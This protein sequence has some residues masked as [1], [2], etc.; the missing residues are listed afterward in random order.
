MFQTWEP[1]GDPFPAK[2]LPLREH[3]AHDMFNHSTVMSNSVISASVNRGDTHTHGKPV[4]LWHAS[5]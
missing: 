1:V 3:P 4:A 2:G 5:I